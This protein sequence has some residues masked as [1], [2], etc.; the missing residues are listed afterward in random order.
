M[1]APMASLAQRTP[2]RWRAKRSIGLAGM[3]GTGIRTGGTNSGQE[4]NG[5]Q[6]A[7]VCVQRDTR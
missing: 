5:Q 3:T 4:H 6:Q 7:P 2:R 1:L